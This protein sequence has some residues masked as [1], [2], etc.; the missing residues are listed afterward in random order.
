MIFFD[1]SEL[2]LPCTST[3]CE[4]EV[5][6]PTTLSEQAEFVKNVPSMDT[7][8]GENEKND[9]ENVETL[10]KDE[11]KMDVENPET[12]KHVENTVFPS[13]CN[14]KLE[15]KVFKP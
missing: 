9:K 8:I 11:Q 13:P 12:E 5:L 2:G 7:E 15:E 3:T 6:K 10:K 14:E 1:D 4:E